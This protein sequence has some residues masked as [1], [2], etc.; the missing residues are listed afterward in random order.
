MKNIEEIN[1]ASVKKILAKKKIPE[2]FAGDTIKIGI[3]IA[4]GKRIKKR[5][6]NKK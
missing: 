5:K 6:S 2:F 4:E 1:S 3:K